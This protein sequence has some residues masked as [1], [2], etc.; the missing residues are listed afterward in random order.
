MQLLMVIYTLEKVVDRHPTLLPKVP[1][2][3]SDGPVLQQ[4]VAFKVSELPVLLQKA[5][6]LLKEPLVIKPESQDSAEIEN[7]SSEDN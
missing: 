2:K 6:G 7:I 5:P 4:L 3:V 1:S